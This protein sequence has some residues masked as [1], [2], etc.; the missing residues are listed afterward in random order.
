MHIEEKLLARNLL[1]K[2]GSCCTATIIYIMAHYVKV[3]PFLPDISRINLM[4]KSLHV[5]KP[6]GD[7]G[8]DCS[9]VIGREMVPKIGLIDNF[10]RNILGW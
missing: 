9:I 3:Y 5:N 7:I 10:K 1:N 6:Y 4:T 2:P 8:I